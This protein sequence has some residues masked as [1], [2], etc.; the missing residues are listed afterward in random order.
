MVTRSRILSCILM[1]PVILGAA[2]GDKEQ[3][4]ET[5]SP[6]ALAELKNAAYRG[7]EGDAE[8]VTLSGGVWEGDPYVEGGASAPRVHLVRDFRLLGDLD[9]DGN[10]EA[11]V[12]LSESSGGSGEFLYV[13]VVDRREGE[14]ENI[15][16]APVGDRVQVRSGRTEGD[17]VYLDVV[18]A[19]PED[20]ACCP[21]ELATRG[22]VLTST[23][24]LKGIAP[25]VA[26]GRLSLETIGAAV[27]VLREWNGNEQAP[28]EPEITFAYQ[29]GGIS[30]SGGC[31]R[32]F[33]T[34][35]DTDT[36]GEVKLGPVG[37]TQMACPESVMAAEIRF[38]QQLGAVKQYSFVAGQLALSYEREGIWGVMLFDRRSAGE[39]P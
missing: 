16:T 28:A 31:N 8:S 35:E 34:V 11:V 39:S 23:G 30:G 27:W 22:W 7:L 33:G 5:D 32:Y 1:V 10:E 25:S 26:P 4:V 36:P 15:A 9:G 2:C 19:G 20:A 29:D 37:S 12:L 38:L 14:L 21:G 24:D 17:R 18:Q 3:A 6:P 13:A